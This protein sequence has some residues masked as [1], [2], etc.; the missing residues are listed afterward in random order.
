MESSR[1]RA[2]SNDLHYLLIVGLTEVD[3]DASAAGM[4][5]IMAVDAHIDLKERLIDGRR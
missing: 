5:I 1:G 2:I 3:V 4:G